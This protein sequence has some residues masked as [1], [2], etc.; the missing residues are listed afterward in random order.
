EPDAHAGVAATNV[1][2]GQPENALEPLR[3]ALRL[4][5]KD[6][7]LSTWQ[8]IMGAVCLHLR[9]DGEAVDWLHRSVALAPTDAFARLFLASAL[10]LSGR[11]DDARAQLA[12]LL[13]LR[14]DFTLSRFKA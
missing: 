3:K 13:R 4:S 6:P 12:E 14:P 8:M 7:S 11:E 5:P 10:A 9:R 2:L 1:L